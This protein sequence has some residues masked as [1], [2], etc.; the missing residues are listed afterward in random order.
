M[1]GSSAVRAASASTA[2]KNVATNSNYSSVPTSPKRPRAVAELSP[3]PSDKASQNPPGGMVEIV[4][5][6][7]SEDDPELVLK[8]SLAGGRCLPSLK[9]S[10]FGPASAMRK[11]ALA[12]ADRWLNSIGASG[13]TS[14]VAEEVTPGSGQCFLVAAP[15]FGSS[16]E[17][18]PGDPLR[19]TPGQ[20]NWV[21]DD[22][23]PSFVILKP[24][25]LQSDLA[26]LDSRLLEKFE[27]AR[28]AIS[29]FGGRPVIVETSISSSPPASC[30]HVLAASLVEEC[31]LVGTERK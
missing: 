17:T 21:F 23:S 4:I 24:L 16:G 22:D 10:V 12:A 8:G 28:T 26:S 7:G 9:L 13:T 25:S 6:G 5:L 20:A 29:S 18:P 2:I 14:L 3:D 27:L 31:L 15:R 30:H 11:A 1:D 19:H